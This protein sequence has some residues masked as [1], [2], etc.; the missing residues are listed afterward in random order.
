MKN[1]LKEIILYILKLSEESQDHE[2]AQN[3]IILSQTLFMQNKINKT[4]KYL[5]DYI[6]DYKWLNTLEFWEGI[7][8]LMIQKE[9]LK[10]DE[11]NKNKDEKEQKSN[12]RNIVFS[13]VFSYSSNMVEFNINKDDIIEMA[14]KFCR[15]FE[16]EK[17]MVDAIIEN[18]NS[19]TNN[20]LNRNKEE[21]EK[22]KKI[23]EE[24]KKEEEKNK[25]EGKEKVEVIKDYFG[26]D[27]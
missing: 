4:K 12:A 27:N 6:R 22:K 21:E 5:V 19:M 8:E 11:I 3:C 20:K 10:N 18:I 2:T 24:K 1:D 26:A 9:I 16:I 15:E 17:G 7:I 25:K 14:Q 23:I 13:Q